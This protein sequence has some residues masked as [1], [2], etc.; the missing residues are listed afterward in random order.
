[1]REKKRGVYKRIISIVLAVVMIVSSCVINPRTISAAAW[2]PREDYKDLKL[3]FWEDEEPGIR[4]YMNAGLRYI[5]ET[6]T[7]P[8]VGLSL[9]H[10]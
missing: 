4:F 1:M 3:R 7:E 5:L 8:S 2:D 6:V 9:I 10:I